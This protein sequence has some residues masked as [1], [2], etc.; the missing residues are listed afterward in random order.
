MKKFL[1]YSFLIAFTVMLHATMM[2]AMKVSEILYTTPRNDSGCFISQKQELNLSIQ[3]FCNYY[4]ELACEVAHL[5]SSYTPTSKSYHRLIGFFRTYNAIH[6]ASFSAT[7]H[8][9]SHSSMD[10]VSYYVFGMRKI[11]T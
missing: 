7:F 6:L 11:I 10:P 2:G 8:P 3:E 5:D 4:A 1:K 9:L